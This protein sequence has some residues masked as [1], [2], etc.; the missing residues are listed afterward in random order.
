MLTQLQTKE[1]YKGKVVM[2]TPETPEEKKRLRAL[3]HRIRLWFAGKLQTKIETLKEYKAR[4]GK[5]KKCR[6][7]KPKKT[8]QVLIIQYEI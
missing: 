4:G 2:L 5:I 6:Y 8:R 7:H 3:N 1:T